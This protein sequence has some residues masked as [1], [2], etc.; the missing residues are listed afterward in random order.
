[1]IYYEFKILSGNK[2]MINNKLINI[3]NS[4]DAKKLNWKEYGVNYLMT[5]VVYI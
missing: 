4:R 2:I 5:Q 1:M 3:L